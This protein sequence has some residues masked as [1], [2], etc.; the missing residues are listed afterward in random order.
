MSEKA[1]FE[2]RVFEVNGETWLAHVEN[3]PDAAANE[4]D[5]R[6]IVLTFRTS[7]HRASARCLDLR[8]SHA[9]LN[10]PTKNYRQEIEWRISSWLQGEERHSKMQMF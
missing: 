5:M 3:N 10:D 2:G 9:L 4:T 6:K 1:L 7:Q 8:L